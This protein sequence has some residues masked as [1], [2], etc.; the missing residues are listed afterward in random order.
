VAIKDKTSKNTGNIV[1]EPN[2]ERVPLRKNIEEMAAYVGEDVIK[3][4]MKHLNKVAIQDRM[5]TIFQ[6]AKRLSITCFDG[7][8]NGSCVK[9]DDGG[10]LMC[11]EFCNQVQHSKCC[12]PPLAKIPDFDWACDDCA[13]DISTCYLFLQATQKNYSIS[14]THTND[15]I[16][17]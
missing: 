15:H 7:E 12:S 9:C 6:W 1:E 17:I 10:N 8:H 3:E 14:E 5:K 11:C 2:F 16:F 13:C 4:S